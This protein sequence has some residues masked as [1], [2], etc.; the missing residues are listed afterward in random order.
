MM[1]GSSKF[2]YQDG[3]PRLEP[4]ALWMRS[5]H[6][7]RDCLYHLLL[8]RGKPPLE[9]NFFAL[10]CERYEI[11]PNYESRGRTGNYIV[12]VLSQ[13][14][15]G[16]PSSGGGKTN[17]YME[18]LERFSRPLGMRKIWRSGMSSRE[19]AQRCKRSLLLLLGARK[20]RECFVCFVCEV[21]ECANIQCVCVCV[22]RVTNR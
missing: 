22:R 16:K 1:M 13:S 11:P 19:D 15:A 2:R 7:G 9:T 14:H 17:Y 18:D 3:W 6:Q 10:E 5:T 8:L 12:L 21:C 4:R 20:I